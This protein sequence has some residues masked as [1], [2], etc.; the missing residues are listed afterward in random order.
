MKILSHFKKNGYRRSQCLRAFLKAKKV[1]RNKKYRKDRFFGVHILFIQGT[2]DKIVRI[3]KRHPIPLT[4]IPLNTIRISLILVKDP[5]NPR[6]GKGVYII[7]CSRGTPYIGET[8]RSINQRIFECAS[9]I[10]H[11]RYHSST[12]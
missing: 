1:H 2:M 6:D 8:G 11:G 3:L 5:M 10:K 9:N 7:P 4:F 12:W